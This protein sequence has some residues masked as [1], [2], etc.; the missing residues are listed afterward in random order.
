M[1]QN[2]CPDL[3]DK[4]CHYELVNIMIPAKI[5]LKDE[6]KDEWRTCYIEYLNNQTLLKDRKLRVRILRTARQFQLIED[7]DR[8][9]QV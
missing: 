4:V 8:A 6:D 9:K 2:Q 3:A 7:S 5:F 1:L